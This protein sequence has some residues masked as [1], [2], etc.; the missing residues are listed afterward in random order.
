MNLIF[1]LLPSCLFPKFSSHGSASRRWQGG[2]QESQYFSRMHACWSAQAGL[3]HKA[4]LTETPSCEVKRGLSLCCR[5]LDSLPLSARAC[6]NDLSTCCWQADWTSFAG[7]KLA[8]VCYKKQKILQIQ[9]NT[10]KTTTTK[11][12]TTPPVTEYTAS[13]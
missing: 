9:T 11:F 8:Y 6:I 13:T 1:S 10:E 5:S 7:N 3:N 2:W 4:V 12:T